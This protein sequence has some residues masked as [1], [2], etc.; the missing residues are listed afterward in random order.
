MSSFSDD[1]F[2]SIYKAISGYNYIPP[3]RLISPAIPAGT[4]ILG[5][6]YI[7]PARS[8][9]VKVIVDTGTNNCTDDI[10]NYQRFLTWRHHT[11][12]LKVDAEFK[13]CYSAM[14]AILWSLLVN[15]SA[16][17]PLLLPFIVL[18]WYKAT[19]LFLF[20]IQLLLKLKYLVFFIM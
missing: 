12:I 10:I 17:W 8:T 6:Y 18:T 14:A 9:I 3:R 13:V 19:Y 2:Y 4:Y 7:S 20:K 15:I 16:K 11:V 1:D 5:F